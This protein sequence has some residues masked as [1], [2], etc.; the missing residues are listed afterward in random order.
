MAGNPSEEPPSNMLDSSSLLGWKCMVAATSTAA[1]A[2][3]PNHFGPTK[4]GSFH[5]LPG[6]ADASYKMA[7]PLRHVIRQA[8]LRK[9]VSN[10]HITLYLKKCKS[11][12]RYDRAFRILWALNWEKWKDPNDLSVHEVAGQ[13]RHLC[14][15]C[16]S[17]ARHAYSALLLVPGF[18]GLRFRTLLKSCKLEWNVSAPKYADF[19][20]ASHV[21][22]KLCTL[23]LDWNS[24]VQVRDREI[25]V[26]RLFHLSRSIDLAQCWRTTTMQGAH[27][28]MKRK[29][30]RQPSWEALLCL[31]DRA[32]SPADLVR[33][34]VQFTSWLPL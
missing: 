33:R 1:R 34:Y 15:I 5:K 21:V 2:A 27:V 25:L 24:E 20:D 4:V 17:E 3:F 19:W 9:K 23:P 11:L 12:T 18:E 14:S 16:A 7:P 29:G 26:L 6:P 13:I 28:L 32:M 30:A 31:P 10:A 22:Q 8:L